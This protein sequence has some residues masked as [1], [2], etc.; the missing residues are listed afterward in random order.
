M[1]RRDLLK[2]LTMAAGGAFCSNGAW[3]SA[4]A[5]VVPETKAALATPIRGLAR[6]N[7]R[8]VQ[9]IELVFEHSGANA[10][11]VINVDGVELE[12][13]PVQS[14]SNR[15]DIFVAAVTANR[16]SVVTLDIG[17]KVQTDTVEL[18]P[19]RKMQVYLL[20]H[21]HHDLGYTDL[22]ADV[23]EKQ[24][25]NITRGIA[26][27]RKT[28]DYP[29]GS[30][31]VWNLEVLWGAD[32][33]MK[34]RSPK[35]KAELIEAVRKGWI[36]L[37]GSYA[38]ELTGLCRP[39]ELAQL[40]R[41]GTELGAECGTKV[42]SAMMSDVP[43]F[44]WGTTTA[45]A[46]AGIRYFSA[47]PN[48]FDRIG[49]FMVTWQDKPFWWV[50]PSGKDKVLVWVPWTGYAMS[51]VM[52]LGTDWVGSYQ[53]RMDDV[54]YPYDISCA[55]W[56]GHGDNAEPDPELSEFVKSW[57]EKYEW[58]HFVIASTTTAFAAFEERYGNQ[59]PQYKGDL[60]PYWE[61]GAGSSALETSM[62]RVAADRLT[63]AAALTAM[64]SPAAYVPATYNDA[65][66][67]VLLYSEHTWGA[68][69]SV[70]DSEN[71]FTTKQW[72]YKRAFAVQ[73]EKKS[74]E[75]LRLALPPTPS[76]ASIDIHNA[77]SWNRSEVVL[78]SKEQSSL[79]DHVADH[80][81]HP[82]PSQRLSTG[83]LAILVADVPA[84]GSSRYTLSAK[85]PHTAE[86][87]VT[88]HDNTLQNKLLRARIDPKTGNIIDL[89]LHGSSQNLID[90]S[91][92]SA[93]N[94]YLFLAGKDLANIERSATPTITI[95][96][97]GP[98]VATLRIESAAPGCN[99][100][101]RRVRLAAGSSHLELSNIVDK[102]RAAL[103]PHPGKGD[104]G[105]EFAQHG[106]KESVQFAFPFSVPDGKMTMDI[107][108][109]D[110][111]PELDQL[112]GSCK[113]WLPVGRWVDVSSPTQGVTW[114]T[115]DAPL[116]EIGGI[117]ATMLGSQKDPSIW[118]KHIEPTQSF[119]SWVMN[120]HWGTNY[121]AYQEGPV[122]FRYAL[123][124]HGEWSADASSRFAI[125][126]SQPLIAAPS[127]NEAL[128]KPSLL[129]VEPADILVLALKPSNDGKAWIVR[130]FGASGESRRAKL[131]WSSP[132]IGKTW[133]S[134]LAEEP[135]HP[136]EGDIPIAGWE[137]TTLRVERA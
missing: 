55:R 72:D 5:A 83:E 3:Q 95:E 23:E 107:A 21:S 87:A 92:N 73:A 31:F 13:R 131:T 36:G 124:P 6:R 130:L 29:E 63:Q 109:A 137:L 39:E 104:Q 102:K 89:H 94:E 121:R 78:L 125:G 111:R 103:N 68:W 108:L 82:I 43:G 54:N 4:N 86:S 126:L 133:E 64:T 85:K 58:P 88:I 101:T 60:T 112:P 1:R 15:F 123:C 14:G 11:A 19:V 76:T 38:N 27:A 74:L 134:N 52:K 118:R 56:S 115:L 35:E 24:M 9:P 30:R 10:T 136:L 50:S 65:W 114:A 57:N 40:F 12:R 18:K 113:N 127:S 16:Q 26:L 110:M 34:R 120:N 116:V 132:A 20:P 79:G 66:R 53:Q 100:L 91:N 41:Y 42:N 75:L 32:L 17:G 84:F 2:N 106:S 48:Y 71:P 81:G 33:Y 59:L 67:D 37:N 90:R 46:Q 96:D 7:G 80:T 22:Q 51:H 45:M 49:T 119:Y 70:S 69:C 25:Q 28:A 47:A 122:E 129:K 62:S 93:A 44:S 128:A 135:L 117:T 98:L 8:S 61:D 77:T 105:S 97:H 99:K